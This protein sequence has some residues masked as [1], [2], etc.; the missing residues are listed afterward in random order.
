MRDDEFWHDSCLAGK[1]RVTLIIGHSED[2]IAKMKDIS[3]RNLLKGSAAAAG[4][5]AASVS[6]GELF[7]FNQVFA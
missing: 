6:F 4:V 7:H 1:K 5:A 2:R 3:R